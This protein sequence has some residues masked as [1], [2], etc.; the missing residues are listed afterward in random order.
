MRWILFSHCLVADVTIWFWW[1]TVLFGW[2]ILGIEVMMD[3]SWSTSVLIFLQLKNSKNKVEKKNYN[4]FSPIFLTKIFQHHSK[5]ENVF[6]IFRENKKKNII[7]N[8]PIFLFLVIFF[9]IKNHLIGKI[10]WCWIANFQLI[11]FKSNSENYN[12]VLC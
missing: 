9:R 3:W 2:K 11:I 7:I 10:L 8:F 4:R 5:C 12:W 6:V 1:V